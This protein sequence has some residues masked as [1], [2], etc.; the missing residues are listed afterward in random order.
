MKITI[1]FD[2]AA[3]TAKVM[4]PSCA[5]EEVVEQQTVHGAA[6][7]AGAY[8]GGTLVEGSAVVPPQAISA[9]I[10]ITTGSALPEPHLDTPSLVSGVSQSEDALNA[11]SPKI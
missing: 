8:S 11:G 10:A 7:D 4:S 3:G 2:P 5:E 1:E 9:G 6:L